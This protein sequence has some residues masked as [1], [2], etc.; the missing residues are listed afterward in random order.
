MSKQIKTE[1]TIIDD[2]TVYV[3]GI[4]KASDAGRLDMRKF[5]EVAMNLNSFWK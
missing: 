4:G 5:I 3:E 2:K 1:V